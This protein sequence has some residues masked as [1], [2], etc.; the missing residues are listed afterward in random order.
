ML[1]MPTN[2]LKAALMCAVSDK[3]PDQRFYLRGVLFEITEC[4]DFHL[5]ST[6]GEK[7]FVG[8]IP[9]NSVR[10]TRERPQGSREFILPFDALKKAAAV[11]GGEVYIEDMGENHY[12]LNGV[13]CVAIDG[14][15]PNWRTVA[16]AAFDGLSNE[17][18][19][20]MEWERVATVEKALRAWSGNNRDTVRIKPRG[21]GVG[22]LVTSRD[23]NAFA[24]VMPQKASDITPE[25]TP[26]FPAPMKAEKV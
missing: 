2:Y 19:T 13:Y 10:W 9:A 14:H 8:R 24:L 22:V 17:Y 18:T 15:F 5:V 7:M 11:R 25:V 21:A 23:T 6:D 12:G 16:Q 26:T 3:S 20:P 4:G 1:R